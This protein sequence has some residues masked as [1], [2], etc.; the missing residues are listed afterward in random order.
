M[1][2]RP[3]KPWLGVTPPSRHASIG[4]GQD[5]DVHPHPPLRFGVTPNHQSVR[6]GVG[7]RFE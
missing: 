2:I 6:K 1:P 7:H 3:S 5:G 4:I